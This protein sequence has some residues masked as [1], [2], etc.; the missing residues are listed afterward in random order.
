LDH[1]CLNYW[2]DED[3]IQFIKQHVKI[4]DNPL[5]EFSLTYKSKGPA[6]TGLAIYKIGWDDVSVE[7][8]IYTNKTTN[9]QFDFIDVDTTDFVNWQSL[10][11]S[12]RHFTP[13]KYERGEDD[14]IWAYA[15]VKID[16]VKVCFIK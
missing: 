9:Q 13:I 12:Q 6:A 3:I 4:S 11:D 10:F 7:D 15:H 8:S 1:D 2:I 16:V 14:E 5:D